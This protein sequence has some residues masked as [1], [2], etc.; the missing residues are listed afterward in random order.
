[1]V[2]GSIPEEVDLAVV[3]AG[4]GGYVTAIRAAQLGMNDP[5]SFFAPHS[6]RRV[7][8]VRN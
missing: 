2:M 1:M 4:V 8:K 6:F 3:G 5:F 7:L